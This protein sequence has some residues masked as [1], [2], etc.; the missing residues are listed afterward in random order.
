MKT[1]SIFKIVASLATAFLFALILGSAT[2]EQTGSNP[3]NFAVLMIGVSCTIAFCAYVLKVTPVRNG[4]A[5]MSLLT[6]V[7][8][9]DIQDN[10]Y[11]GNEF[12]TRS[13][14]HSMWVMHK[15]VHVP[16]AGAKPTVEKDRS[17]FPASIGS[18]SDTE[19]TYNLSQFTTDP[20]L[21]QNIEELQIS[22]NKRASILMNIM[23]SLQFVVATQTLYSWAPSGATRIVST[24]GS[25]STLNLPHSTATG[26]R[27]MITVAD[28][29]AVKSILDRDNIP[30]AG[31][32]LLVPQYM[33]NIDI[34]NI[35]GI[36]QAYA[37]GSPVM[38]TGVV[39]RVM[40]FDIMIRSE[41]L[42]YD[43][44]GTPVIKGINGD[45]TLTSPATTD[46]GAAL[47]YHPNYVARALGSIT[48]YYDAGSN[49]NGKPEYFGSLF[50]AEVMHG[51]TKL[52]TGQEGIV[53]L[54][55]G[56]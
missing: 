21:L 5:Y 11:M 13:T 48:P 3:C 36:V 42:V 45:G 51:A 47:A 38:P 20:I 54:V 10:L 1:K 2:Q 43:N 49:G 22:Y 46:Q 44:T 53:A 7:W 52:R 50:S 26:S 31:R 33:Y 16:Q 55:Q 28:L 37:F 14:D 34:L 19:L 29:T 17:V 8:A 4:M 56:T 30:S 9:T 25:T 39:A 41:V 27:K 40:G 18:R 24:S 23:S 15:T 6:E 35:S 12:M 32:I